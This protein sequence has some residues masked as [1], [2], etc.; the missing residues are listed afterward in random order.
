M[1]SIKSQI[2]AV[3]LAFVFFL[4]LLIQNYLMAA[5]SVPVIAA[6]ILAMYF[7]LK[8]KKNSMRVCII[9]Y[10]VIAVVISIVETNITI[11]SVLSGIMTSSGWLDMPESGL[12]LREYHYGSNAYPYFLIIGILPIVLLAAFHLFLNDLLHNSIMEISI[13][14]VSVCILLT[15]LVLCGIPYFLYLACATVVLIWNCHDWQLNTK[16]EPTDKA[17]YSYL[18][19]YK[20]KQ[21]EKDNNV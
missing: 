19:T 2:P 9:I 21:K 3:V 4:A 11:R 16:K 1:R 10:F 14:V 20:K 12:L 7:S 5:V 8:N 13:S 15:A 17:T 18:E 6:S